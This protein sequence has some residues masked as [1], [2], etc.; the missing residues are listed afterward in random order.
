MAQNWKA[1]SMLS[2]GNWYK[3]GITETGVYRISITDLAALNGCNVN[4][5]ALYGGNAVQMDEDNSTSEVD[6][7]I[8]YAI[9]VVDNNCNGKI[10]GND[11]ILFWGEGV[12]TWR[13]DSYVGNYTHQRHSYSNSN[14]Y[15]LRTDSPT[16]RTIPT[17]VGLT[18]NQGDI[19]QFTICSVYEKELSNT[20]NSGQIWVGEKFLNGTTKN[21]AVPF[22]QTVSSNITTRIALAVP[23]ATGR[24]SITNGNNT[25]DFSLNSNEHHKVFQY[26]YSSPSLT[27]S[28][29]ASGSTAGYLDYIEM[30]SLCS[31]QTIGVEGQLIHNRQAL[32]NGNIARHILNCTGSFNVWDVTRRD[33]CIRMETT[34]QG[35]NTSF[36]NHTDKARDYYLFQNTR[37]PDN[38]SHLSNQDIHGTGAPDMVIVCHKDFLNQSRRIA[39]MHSMEDGID[40]LVVTQDQVFNE[41]SSGKQDP[42]AIREMMRMFYTRSS[43]R[44]KHL[45]LFGKA[46]FDNRDI[47]EHHFPSVVTY[48][49]TKGFTDYAGH[50]GSDDIYGYLDANET[51]MDGNQDINIG[52]LPA[53][54]TDE[55]NLLTQKIENYMM[56]IDLQ[57][58]ETSGDWRTYVTL[59]S[60][61]ADPSQQGDIDFITSS[62]YLAER[63]EQQSPWLNL[64]KIYAD[65]YQQQSGTIG[66]YYPDVNN[67][68]KRRMDYGCLLLNYIGHGSE[69]YIG[70]ERYMDLTDIDNFKNYNKLPFFV[71][72]TCSFGKYDKVDGVCGAE[73]FVLAQGAGVGCVSAA[74][75]ISH[76]RTFNTALVT[77]SLKPGNTI[78]EALRIAKNQ[79]RSN[80]NVAIT[81]LGDPA[82]SLSF[83]QYNIVVTSINGQ[84]VAEGVNDSA[85]VLSRVTIEGEIR[86]RQD[87][88]QQDFNGTIYPIVFDR[89]SNCRSLANDNPGTEIDFTQ[90]KNILYKGRDTV[91]GGR[92]RYTF[93]VP[94]DVDFQYGQARLSHYAKSM[95]LG[96]DAA[97]AYTNLMLGG[98]DEN[99]DISETRPDIRLYIG[100]T[101]FFDGGLADEN[102]TLIAL[103]YD[104][105]GINSVGSGL[106]HDITAI[107]DNNFNDVIILNDFYETDVTRPDWGILRYQFANLTPGKHTLTVKAWNI[108]NYSASATVNF[109]VK[110]SD[111]ASIGTFKSYPNP[112]S[113][114]AMLHVDHNCKDG[115]TDARIDIYSL[116]GNRI[117]SFA[118][119]P[120]EGSYSIG[121]I[122]W[123]F[124]DE[125]GNGVAN[126]IY[127]A[128]VILTTREGKM[129]TSSIKIVLKK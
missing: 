77:N 4:Q 73:A 43:G 2:S 12:T 3:I 40:V 45:M 23:D 126:G 66:S 104:T 56:R 72:S 115:I 14:Y 8:P 19:N 41:F 26:T 59:L 42:I 122:R 48:Q 71:T 89:K 16:S 55:A 79:Y 108:Y 94:R 93:V 114:Y 57:Q 49:S 96:V 86:N 58:Q 88:I 83:P 67:A 34:T 27:L 92:F 25:N 21:I 103:L 110:G 10:D 44:T 28:F 82:L 30:S 65:A 51:G 98:F 125:S 81:L 99:A 127:L 111:T 101:N 61:D 38:I 91:I 118:P 47:L 9:Q 95:D 69:L 7:L 5:V 20:H 11:Y 78:G 54:T 105:I 18:A 117:R 129:L 15:F 97:G 52:R 29:A 120:T 90:Q 53:K 119:T 60:D 6:D 76:L 39:N 70:T 113:D 35:G 106:G 32:G 102:A 74:R 33:S 121:P 63:I 62:E 85:K 24:F 80:Q 46:T 36:V 17:Q 124:T 13:Y 1:Q 22:E 107:L 100:D 112:A 31:I 75:P 87:V 116:Q 109:V 37:T 50:S 68:L 84:P 123:D 64:D 128:R